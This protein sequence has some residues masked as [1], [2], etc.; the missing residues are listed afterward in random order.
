[1]WDLDRV[2]SRAVS[3]RQEVRRSGTG[4]RDVVLVVGRVER[5]AVP[6][7]KLLLAFA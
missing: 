2:S 1:M 4:V 7:T 6:T 3:S 5:F